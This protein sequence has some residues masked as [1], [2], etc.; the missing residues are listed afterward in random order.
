MNEQE[1]IS[2]L[3]LQNTPLVG[4]ITAKK[5]IAHFGSAYAIFLQK[6]KDIERIWGIG[7]AISEHLF[8]EQHQKEAQTEWDY[9]C[10]NN[11]R[12]CTFNDPDYP[13]YLAQAPDSP[14]LFFYDGNINLYQKKI[15]S[16]VGTR[17]ITP[18]GISFC[19][20]LIRDLAFLKQELVI[21]S[22]FAYGTDITAHKLAMDNDIQTIACLAHGL[23][24]LYPA[25]HKKYYYAM[26]QNGGFITDF[27]HKNKFDRK[28]FLSR[29]RIIA[30]L[31]EATIVVESANKG[32]SLVTADIAFSYDRNVFALPGRI[33]DKYSQGCNDLIKSCKAQIITSADDII[34]NLNWN[35]PKNTPPATQLQLFT[36]LSQ[37]E[38]SIC[39]YLKQNGNQPIDF[40][41]KACNIPIY[42]LPHILLELEMKNI[43]LPLPGKVFTLQQ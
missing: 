26:T 7:N 31:S 11:I 36:S 23:D 35:L 17:Q 10:K 37:Q 28:N 6:K 8:D 27:W 41:A 5:L 21:V 18:Y 39:N 13:H 42:K 33:Q 40:I 1:I 32:G 24:T 38:Q 20:E 29:N 30:G 15:I 12:F 19:Q 14:I 43:V 4:D 16:I 34:K 3:R 22:G 25:S 9:I 2:L